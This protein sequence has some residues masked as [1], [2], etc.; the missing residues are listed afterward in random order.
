MGGIVEDFDEVGKLGHGFVSV[1]E[2]DAGTQ[3]DSATTA[4]GVH[5]LLCMGVY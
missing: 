4:Y 2:L 5:G 3:T 1:D